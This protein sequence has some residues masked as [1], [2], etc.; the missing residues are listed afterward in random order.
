MI[1]SFSRMLALPPPRP[2][3]GVPGGIDPAPLIGS[4][5]QRGGGQGQGDAGAPQRRCDQ[6]RLHH[7]VSLEQTAIL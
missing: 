1:V 4:A 6:V 3:G 7:V 5:G 2:P